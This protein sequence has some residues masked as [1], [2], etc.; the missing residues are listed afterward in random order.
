VLDWFLRPRVL[1]ERGPPL[2]TEVSMNRHVARRTTALFTALVCAQQASAQ[3]F[4]HSPGSIPQGAPFNDS[5]TWEVDF[6]DIDLDG[7]WDVG[8]ADAGTISGGGD[9]NDQNR[10]WVNQGGMQGGTIGFFVDAT[11]VQAPLVS[12]RSADIE[13][14]DFDGDGDMDIYSVNFNTNV[15]GDQGCRWWTNQGGL[16]GGSAGFYV[17]ETALRWVGLGGPGSSVNPQNVL[18]SGGFITWGHDQDFADIDNDGDCDLVAAVE[19][20]FG[21]GEEPTRIFLNDGLGFFSE[22]NPSGHQASGVGLGDGDSALWCEGLQMNG[23]T[24]TTGANADITTVAREVSVGDID[25]DLDLDVLLLDSGFKSPRMFRN[26]LEESGALA[27]RDV[28]GLTWPFG[29]GNGAGKWEQ[30]FADF[31]GDLDIDVYGLNW[32]PDQYDST[33]R[34]GGDGTFTESTLVPNSFIGGNWSFD[35]IDYDADGQLDVF[36]CGTASPQSDWL[37]DNRFAGGPLAFTSVSN[38]VSGSGSSGP[39]DVDTADVDG[40]GDYDLLRACQVADTLLLNVL[41]LPDTTAPRLAHLEQPADHS[42]G[43][44]TPIRAHHYDNAPDYLVVS[45]TNELFHS[46]DGAPFV[47][48]PMTWSGGQVLRGE[49]PASAVGNVR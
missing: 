10:L 29:W 30:D 4:V 7:D 6:A 46:V 37:F 9:D 41:N 44:A 36:V 14:V 8:M 31:D 39:R 32:S 25:N 48:A 45:S 43:Q 15:N 33:L 12:D 17:D 34:G 5:Y 49:L 13:F 26:R 19:G 22:F 16:Q 47:S 28:T 27:F 2:G 38:P 23:T 21:L 24:N 35:L 40:D 1:A 20:P 3:V 42:S 11:A 18:S